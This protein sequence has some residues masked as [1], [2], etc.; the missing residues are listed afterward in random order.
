[1]PDAPALNTRPEGSHA[2]MGDVIIGEDQNVWN[3]SSGW[4]ALG[5][6]QSQEVDLPVEAEQ[7]V[8]API[9]Q[10]ISSQGA[11]SAIAG[12]DAAK[13]WRASWVGAFNAV[14][15]SAPSALAAT[16]VVYALFPAAFLPAGVLM[17]L[18]GLA[19]VHWM[20]A[21]SQRP[22]M[23]TI[24]LLE[25]TI[26]AA[27]L[28]QMQPRLAAWGLPDTPG[29]LLALMCVLGALAGLFR[30]ALFMLRADRFARLV[31][32]PVF[33]G[34]MLSVVVALLFSQSERLWSLAQAGHPVVALAVICI[35]SAA[36]ASGVAWRKPQW[37]AAALGLAAGALAGWGC[38]LWLPGVSMVMSEQASSWQLPVQ[39]ADFQALAAPSVA[40]GALIPGLLLSGAVIGVSL[41]LNTCIASETISQQ[42]DRYATV[43]QQSGQS[44]LCAASGALGAAP[45]SASTHSSLAALRTGPLLGRDVALAGLLLALLALTGLLNSIALAA[46]AAV[47][48]ID[49]LLMV[50]RAALS[51]CWQ[52]LRGK[53][54]SVSVR[55]DSL[56]ILAVVASSVV[57]NGVVGIIVGLFAGLLLFGMRNA[58]PPVRFEWTGMQLSANAHRDSAES[59]VLAE[60]G[61]R[62]QILELESELF[63]G[64]VRSLDETLRSSTREARV[65]VLDWSR[66]RHVDSSIALSLKRWRRSAQ[67]REPAQ[68][69]V[70]LHA[71]AGLQAGNAREFL[72]QHAHGE[73]QFPD[74]D[75]ALELAEN[76]LIEEYLPQRDEADES[77][78]D[79]LPLFWGLTDAHMRMLDVSMPQHLFRAGEFVLQAGQPVDAIY[80][81]VQGQLAVVAYDAHGHEVR[82]ALARRGGVLGEIGFLDQGAATT[83]VRAITDTLVLQLHRALLGEL[84]RDYPE[85]LNQILINLTRI[86]SQKVIKTNKLAL[87][88]S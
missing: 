47:M 77:T 23:Q 13:S 79:V 32:A 41:F 24:R 20:N 38:A 69:V 65:L 87:S 62:L 36:V 54:R 88:R 68:S 51:T 50:D 4:Q 22:M 2:G 56:L 84:Q 21:L 1:M 70:M 64:S 52:W 5:Q 73:R 81:I 61:H 75:H 45:I 29:V 43:W 57:F 19:A 42:D 9:A 12:L 25:A 35:V 3:L 8:A 6:E 11:A 59:A 31:P 7:P 83:D 86:L 74:L 44:L 10:T 15:L 34:Y 48:L 78:T 14:A 66:V 26:L 49:A 17:A 27:A 63:F 67:M 60:H 76:T 37:P 85:I 28:A 55:D 16:A 71:G 80:V 82:L 53:S 33:A 18:V 58:R 40:Y 46:V 39:L 72:N 30:A